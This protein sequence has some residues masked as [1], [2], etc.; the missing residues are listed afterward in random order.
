MLSTLWKTEIVEAFSVKILPLG[1]PKAVTRF[2]L[3]IPKMHVFM[4]DKTFDGY[5]SLLWYVEDGVVLNYKEEPEF[6]KG[7]VYSILIQDRTRVSDKNFFRLYVQM[8]E[9]FGAV[10]LEDEK[11]V[12]VKQ[13]R[14]K[15]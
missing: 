13:F 11:F 10:L 3:Q 14:K 9:L 12:S 7:G 5:L 15:I 4:S 6:G 8:F 1:K 2:M